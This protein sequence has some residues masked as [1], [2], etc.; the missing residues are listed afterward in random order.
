MRA[1]AVDVANGRTGQDAEKGGAVSRSDTSAQ[2]EAKAKSASGTHAPWLGE[3]GRAEWAVAE[4]GLR[5]AKE[6]HCGRSQ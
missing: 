3:A 4:F 5:R 1:R 6:V 2:D